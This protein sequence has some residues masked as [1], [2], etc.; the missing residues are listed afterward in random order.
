MLGYIQNRVWILRRLPEE[1][2]KAEGHWHHIRGCW[3]INAQA[4]RLHE[5]IGF[6]S[7]EFFGFDSEG[8]EY[9]IP[10]TVAEILRE[11]SFQ[12]EPFEEQFEFPKVV[13]NQL[14]LDL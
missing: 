7:V 9:T 8:R 4:V 1:V 3:G 13:V 6:D 11:K 12:Y 14:T 10:R 2:A 5:E